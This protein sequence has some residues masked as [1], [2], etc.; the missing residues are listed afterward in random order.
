M[1][2]VDDVVERRDAE[3]TARRHATSDVRPRSAASIVAAGELGSFPFLSSVQLGG[4]YLK[5]D[6][7]HRVNITGSY[8]G[9]GAPHCERIFPFS[10]FY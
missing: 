2:V 7:T 3:S 10:T 8:C 9:N 6:E 1:R 4:A 5:G